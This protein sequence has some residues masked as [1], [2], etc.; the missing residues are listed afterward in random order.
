MHCEEY[1]PA[2]NPNVIGTEKLKILFTWKIIATMLII[3]IVET[4]VIDVLNER[5]IVWLALRLT[6]SEI[7]VLF[8]SNF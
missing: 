4:V 2:I 5:R 7:E 8:G 3:I 1:V 6:N